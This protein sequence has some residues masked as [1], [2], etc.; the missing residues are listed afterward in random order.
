MLRIMDRRLL[1]GED[2]G[3]RVMLERR[4]RRL[5]R[6]GGVVATRRGDR[7]LVVRLGVARGLEQRGAEDGLGGEALRVGG[8]RRVGIKAGE[9]GE[10]PERQSLGVDEFGVERGDGVGGAHGDA[11]WGG[12][13]ASWSAGA[14][15]QED[16]GACHENHRAGV[17]MRAE[18]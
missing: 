9:C 15:W 12:D 2:T 17:V 8:L 14:G 13:G 10:G 11:P 1:S 4:G 7:G 16:A 3:R 5:G 18:K 6:I